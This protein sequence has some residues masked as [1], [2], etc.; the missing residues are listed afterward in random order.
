MG[1]E[2]FGME[3]FRGALGLPSFSTESASEFHDYLL[4]SASHN[5]IDFGFEMGRGSQFLHFSHRLFQCGRVS[6]ALVRHNST[7]GF[8][9]AKAYRRE[10]SFHFVLGGR[11]RLR[12]A[13]GEQY[14]NPGHVFVL[15]PDQTSTEFWEND[16]SL[17]L[18]RLDRQVLD[19]TISQELG[20]LIDTTVEFEPVMQDPGVAAWL[21]HVVNDLGRR[22]N[23]PA[24][25]ANWRIT[26]DLER[27]LLTMLLTGL[28]N[29]D[30][31]DLSRQGPGV[32]PY[33]VRR[34]QTFIQENAREVL[35]INAIAEHAGVRPRSLFYGF[36]RWLNTT[37]MALVRDARLDVARS[38]LQKA[39]NR[40]G[41]V[42]QAAMN[43]GFTDFSQF[44][45]LY[46]VR[47]NETP[48]AT[49]KGK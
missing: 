13:F 34:A 11:C 19:H 40:G 17:I 49:L 14:V 24:I 21:L 30:S 28:P 22:R 9:L 32:A 41:T 20:R 16:C 47:F 46:K 5:K 35:T 26:R 33:Y 31:A 15:P 48:S 38:E 2:A 10:I 8:S 6:L 45:R 27:M 29:S 44:S 1:V 4:R 42:S 37:P 23:E 12:G 43:A 18:V 3:A 36:K 39:R 25:A 7:H